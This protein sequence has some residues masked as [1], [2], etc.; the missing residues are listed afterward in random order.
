MEELNDDHQNNQAL[1]ERLYKLYLQ[2]TKLNRSKLGK[3]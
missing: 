3:F 2:Y 1:M